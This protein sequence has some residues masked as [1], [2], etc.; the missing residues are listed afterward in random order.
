MID[1]FLARGERVPETPQP[2]PATSTTEKLILFGQVQFD[3]WLLFY[4]FIA[5]FV[6]VLLF[7]LAFLYY[8]CRCDAINRLM[9]RYTPQKEA[10]FTLSVNIILPLFVLFCRVTQY[11][12]L[13]QSVENDC[14]KRMEMMEAFVE[15]AQ[16]EKKKN[17]CAGQKL[18]EARAASGL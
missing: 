1:K 12:R 3:M 6:L 10:A 7:L 11:C 5:A 4:S 9:P 8:T 15:E 13:R 14:M 18:E 17:S 16:N 2:G